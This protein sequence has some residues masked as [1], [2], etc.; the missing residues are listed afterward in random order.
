MYIR[1]S[2]EKSHAKIARVVFCYLCTQGTPVASS[3]KN[4]AA[5]RKV[6]MLLAR[7]T[8]VF[9]LLKQ[10]LTG[11][12]ISMRRQKICYFYINNQEEFRTS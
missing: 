2:E 3:Q 7:Q 11:P 9:C 6:R 4:S 10:V 8:G 1:L 12:A 5:N